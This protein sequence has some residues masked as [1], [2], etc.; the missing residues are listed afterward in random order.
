MAAEIYAVRK[1]EEIVP[2]SRKKKCHT[3]KREISQIW[4]DIWEIS[5]FLM[6]GCVADV[7]ATGDTAS[8]ELFYDWNRLS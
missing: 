2:Y 8:R 5:L 3:V 6:F 4:K 1:Y 7:Y